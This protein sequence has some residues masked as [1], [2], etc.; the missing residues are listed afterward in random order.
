M[1]DLM[2]KLLL[3][4]VPYGWLHGQDAAAGGVWSGC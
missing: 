2:M 3:L 4:V 1:P